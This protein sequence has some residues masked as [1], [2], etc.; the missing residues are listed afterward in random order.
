MSYQRLDTLYKHFERVLTGEEAIV[1]G[2][3]GQIM[4]EI[5]FMVWR[6]KQETAVYLYYV[7][8]GIYDRYLEELQQYEKKIVPGKGYDAVVEL[9][10]KAKDYLDQRIKYRERVR[11]IVY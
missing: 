4:K 1:P 7:P 2:A 10:E 11:P 9:A 6:A 5:S 8:K 3:N